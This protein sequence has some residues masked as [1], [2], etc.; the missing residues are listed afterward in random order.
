MYQNLSKSRLDVSSTF[1][2][3]Q[4]PFVSS[5]VSRTESSARVNS[6][7]PSW[8]LRPKIRGH[9][10]GGPHL[11]QAICQSTLQRTWE[12]WQEAWRRWASLV[13]GVPEGGEKQILN[14]RWLSLTL[15]VVVPRVESGVTVPI[16][17]LGLR[18]RGNVMAT[19]KIMYKFLRYLFW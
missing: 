4:T 19:R 13:Y 1:T 5:S 8:V 10:L 3:T 14:S 11:K 6:R 9:E 16:V 17:I 18:V 7:C 12:Q 2:F 15:N